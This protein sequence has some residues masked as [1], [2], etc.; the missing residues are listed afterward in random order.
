MTNPTTAEMLDRTLKS[1]SA[2]TI[3]LDRDL[4]AIIRDAANARTALAQGHAVMGSTLGAGPIGHQAPFDVAMT[5]A[6]ITALIDQALMLGANG[7]QI[8]AAYKVAV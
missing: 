1:I 5:T 4:G 3:K 6:R 8:T 7:S 2:A